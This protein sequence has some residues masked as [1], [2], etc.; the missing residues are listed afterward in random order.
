MWGPG[1]VGFGT[2][3]YKYASGR[4]ADWFLTG[5]APRKQDLTLYIMAGPARY[6]TLLAKLGTYKTGRACLYIKRLADVNQ[7]VL[8]Q[9]VSAS[10]RHMKQ[11]S[12][13]ES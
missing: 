8:Q 12:D 11:A 9:L 3:H 13:R 7:T 1:I 6:K 10:V 2:Y 5:F 4:Q